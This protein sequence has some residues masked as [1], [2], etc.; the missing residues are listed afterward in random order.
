[1]P[2]L[3]EFLLAEKPTARPRL[4]FG[5]VLKLLT[6]RLTIAELEKRFFALFSAVGKL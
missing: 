5:F 6:K 2:R 3:E 1:M 4:G